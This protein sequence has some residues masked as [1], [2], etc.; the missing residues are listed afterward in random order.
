V[1]FVCDQAGIF[2]TQNSL[3]ALVH[4]SRSLPIP[5]C[6]H[7]VSLFPILFIRL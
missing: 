3:D 2:A 7:D 4:G 6:S 5:P 1:I